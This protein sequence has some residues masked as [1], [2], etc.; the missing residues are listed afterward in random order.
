MQVIRETVNAP[1]CVTSVF[2]PPSPRFSRLRGSS[3]GHL[4]FG[5]SPMEVEQPAVGGIGDEGLASRSPFLHGRYRDVSPVLHR[6]ANRAVK[7]S[8][9]P[10]L[11]DATTTTPSTR[12]RRP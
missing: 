2:H 4:P 9:G 12:P 1:G 10:T 11:D 8:A 6:V 5:T 3:G 7:L